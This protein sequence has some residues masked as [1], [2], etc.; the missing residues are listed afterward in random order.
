MIAPMFGTISCACAEQSEIA[1]PVHELKTSGD[2]PDLH[3]LD[4]SS[5]PISL[6]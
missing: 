4:G 2:R 5:C 1:R 3:Q 6:P